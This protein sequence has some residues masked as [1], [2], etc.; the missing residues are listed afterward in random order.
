[1]PGNRIGDI[2]HAIQETIESAGFSVVRDFVGHGV[3]E[4]YMRNLK[5][6]ILERKIG[7]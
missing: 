5:Y 2:S 7:E 3:V 6:L 4:P 1:M